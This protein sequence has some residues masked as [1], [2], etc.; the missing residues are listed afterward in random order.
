[1]LGYSDSNKDGGIL[2]SNYQLFKAQI[3]LNRLCK[4]SG[5]EPIFFH[6]RGGSISRGGG[7]VYN[8]ILAQPGGTIK[9]KIKITEQGEMISAKYLVPEIAHRSIE[10]AVS[11]VMLAAFETQ[12]QKQ[13]DY[14]DRHK[15]LFERLSDYSFHFYRSLIEDKNFISF[16]RK[17]TPIDIIEKIEIGSRP[18]SRKKGSELKNL[19]AIPWVFAWTQN[20]QTIS[21]WFGFGYA[22]DRCIK[23]RLVD[24]E[25][26]SGIFIDWRF[27]N[28]LVQNIEM[29]LYKTDMVIAHEYF[30]KYEDQAG[31]KELFNKIGIEYRRSV[32]AILKITGEKSLLDNNKMLQ[33]SLSLRNPYLDPISYIQVRFLNEYRSKVRKSELKKKMLFLLS[34]TV[35]GLAAGVRNTG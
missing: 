13:F 1:M 12:T 6:G 16:F 35:N 10:Y 14:F 27:F 17:I 22:I 26:L 9:G 24:W 33:Q 32:N 2:C 28:T 31:F 34:S 19:R 25:T 21:G 3:E 15:E 7:P 23:E 5:I 18:S 29:V 4:L 8:S 20:R 11:A 30:N